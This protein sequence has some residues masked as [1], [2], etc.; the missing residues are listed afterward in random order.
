MRHLG[1]SFSIVVLALSATLMSACGNSGPVRG[2]GVMKTESPSVSGFSS[3]NLTGV[4]KLI[5]EQ[6]GTESLTIDA[7][8]NIL[9]LLD[10]TVTNNQLVLGKKADANF[11]ATKDIV[12]R[13]TVKELG[14]VMVSGSGS[15]TAASITSEMF[16]IELGGAGSINIDNLQVASQTVIKL[17]GTGTITIGALQSQNLSAN[18]AGAGSIKIAGGAVPNQLVSISGAG[19]YDAE[20]LVSDAIQMNLSGAGNA[21]VNVTTSMDVLIGGSGSVIYVGDGIVN[22][23]KTGTGTVTKK[24]APVP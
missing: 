3:I 21:V 5:I 10:N 11:E 4:G 23:T 17:G 14:Q 15:A 13:V 6:S 18:I 24:S 2:S 12:Y 19:N 1:R 22:Q 16:N 20:A 8:D 7:V 9:P